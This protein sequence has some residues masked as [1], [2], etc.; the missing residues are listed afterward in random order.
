[1]RNP[2]WSREELI[3]A[4]DLYM[5]HRATGPNDPEVIALSERL[6]RLTIHPD[7][8]DA[9]R[10]R[11]P[12]GVY[13]KLQ[14]F[15]RFDPDDPAIGLTRGNRLEEELW[16]EFVGEPYKLA[17]Q[18]KLLEQ[19]TPARRVAEPPPEGRRALLEADVAR[20]FPDDSDLNAILRQLI[21]LSRRV[22]SA[23][24]LAVAGDEGPPAS[25]HG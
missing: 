24:E 18:V 17:E 5:R 13:M 22:P 25:P 8:P 16:R 9:E 4:L 10:F 14:N 21:S 20:A 19:R 7:R 2:P 1:M 12:N 23:V 15:R 3:L 11:N 6:N